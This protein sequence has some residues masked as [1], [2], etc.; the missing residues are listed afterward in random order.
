MLILCN[1]GGHFGDFG[2]DVRSTAAD[3][4]KHMYTICYALVLCLQTWFQKT[5][6]YKAERC[7]IFCF[8]SCSKSRNEHSAFR[9]K[10]GS[11]FVI[12]EVILVILAV[13]TTIWTPRGLKVPQVRDFTDFR[14][15]SQSLSEAFWDTISAFVF[16]SLRDTKKGGL[17]GPSKL[18]PFLVDS[19]VCPEGLRRVPVST[20][21]QFSLLQPCPKRAPK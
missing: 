18:D 20:A 4:F 15:K 13:R 14:T 6:K 3:P 11:F 1:F 12:L 9:A 16:W 8:E 19:G 10:I 2:C 17:G 5:W 21:A 7:P